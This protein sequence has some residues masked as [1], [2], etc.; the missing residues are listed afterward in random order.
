MGTFQSESCAPPYWSE[1][2]GCFR[3]AQTHWRSSEADSDTFVLLFL[4]VEPPFSGS[5]PKS[6]Y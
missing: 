1:R 2:V 4:V 6:V 5:N 3:F